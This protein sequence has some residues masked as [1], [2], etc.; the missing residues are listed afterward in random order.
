M[1]TSILRTFL[2]T[3][4]F[5]NTSFSFFFAQVTIGSNK[6]PESYSILELVTVG[7]EGGLRLPQLTTSQ[8][9]A[10][11]LHTLSDQ[12]K[13]KNARGLAIFN[14]ETKCF[15]FWNSE[16]WISL[17]SGQEPGLVNF[18][19]CDLIKVVGVYDMDK[20][21]GEQTVRID[22]PVVVK[23]LGTY[24]YS[25]VCNG[26]NFMAVG[27]FIN[28][29]P[30][31]VSLY[32]DSSVGNPVSVGTHPATVT[33]TPVDAIPDP[34]SIVCNNVNIKFVNRSSSTLKILNIAGDK[35][36]TGLTSSGGNH[37]TNTVYDFLG[38]WITSGIG[39]T[40]D[41]IPANAAKTYA[42][43]QNV[44]IVNVPFTSMA[45]LQ[46]HLQDASIV[47]CGASLDYSFGFAQL[48]REW[49]AAGK[50]IIM[51]TGDKIEEST[52]S[53]ALGYYIE[54]GSASN[55]S[56]KCS[57]LPQVFSTSVGGAPYNLGDGLTIPHSGSNCG[58]ISSNKGVVFMTV[59]SGG[60]PSAFADIDNG[61]FIFGDKF[62]ETTST[63]STEWKNYAKVMVDIFAWS[64]KNAP[65]Y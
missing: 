39:V 12:D 56:T 44:Q 18:S 61:V 3:L 54:D 8:R 62:G 9:N 45:T 13:K 41:G 19:N 48:L 42:G 11:G 46:D 63:S 47:W 50:G 1:K 40:I 30:T 26:V 16:E 37:T 21:L 53:D 58:Y 34:V 51:I 29:G 15:E 38:K 49:F 64:L 65:I 10:L 25:A 52:V 55:G 2:I 27:T 20:G 23:K 35:N 6:A 14:T 28:L 5:V 57:R 59:G 32:V 31:T 22:V 17:C 43:T 33:I 7:T 36:K 60:Y 4:F 24:Q